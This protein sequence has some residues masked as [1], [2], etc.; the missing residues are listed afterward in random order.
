MKSK[1]ILYFLLL[2]LPA[3]IYSSEKDKMKFHLSCAAGSIVLSG[4]YPFYNH[5]KNEMKAKKIIKSL[6]DDIEEHGI[7]SPLGQ[8]AQAKKNIFN[9]RQRDDLYMKMIMYDFGTIILSMT[10]YS[11]FKD[12]MIDGSLL[13]QAVLAGSIHSLVFHPFCFVSNNS[14]HEMELKMSDIKVDQFAQIPLA[15]NN[16]IAILANSR[17]S[18]PPLEE[19]LM[20]SGQPSYPLAQAHVVENNN[21]VVIQVDNHRTSAIVNK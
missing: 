11:I 4:L 7:N 3:S 17:A 19:A 8:C 6:S 1:K 16:N 13:P 2:L 15:V 12:Y 9:I 14:F 5:I 20:I 21:P 10:I 18:L